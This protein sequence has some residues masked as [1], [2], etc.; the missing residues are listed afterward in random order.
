MHIVTR[1]QIR[2]VATK[3]VVTNYI[4]HKNNVEKSNK[5]FGYFDI[6]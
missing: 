2:S 1:N 3:N 4:Y 6:R 5:A